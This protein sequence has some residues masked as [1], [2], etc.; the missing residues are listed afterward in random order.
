MFILAEGIAQFPKPA[1]RTAPVFLHPIETKV[2]HGA[3][4]AWHVFR[5]TERSFGLSILKKNNA[6]GDSY[7]KQITSNDAGGSD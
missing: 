6:E 7:E 1:R 2:R 5:V 4:L 3:D